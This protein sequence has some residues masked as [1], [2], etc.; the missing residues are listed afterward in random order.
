M[1]LFEGN[2]FHNVEYYHERQLAKKNEI[3]KFSTANH[4]QIINSEN[5]LNGLQSIAKE[6]NSDKSEASNLQRNINETCSKSKRD[7]G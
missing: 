5:K 2:A 1:V 7:N 4:I 3:S 6:S